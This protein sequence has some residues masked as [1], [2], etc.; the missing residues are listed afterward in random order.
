MT[1]RGPARLAAFA[2]RCANPAVSEESVWIRAH[3][4]SPRV[5]AESSSWLFLV[6]RY[7]VHVSAFVSVRC[8]YMTTL[9]KIKS[10]GQ[11]QVVIG[12]LTVLPLLPFHRNAKANRNLHRHVQDKSFYE[13]KICIIPKS[14]NCHLY[15][16]G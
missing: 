11:A 10:I 4:H 13:Y 7:F 12:S 3:V 2:A 15:I 16:P 8:M 1:C 6:I 5:D 14:E 9:V